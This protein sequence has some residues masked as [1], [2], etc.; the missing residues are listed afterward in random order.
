[1]DCICTGEDH[2]F[3]CIDGMDPVPAEETLLDAY[4]DGPL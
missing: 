1:M 3:F 4:A 2:D